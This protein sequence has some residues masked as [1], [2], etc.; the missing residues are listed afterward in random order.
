MLFPVMVVRAVRF[1]LLRGSSV[2]SVVQFWHAP[3]L[4]VNDN[5]TAQTIFLPARNV[6]GC[7]ET[8]SE[9]RGCTLKQCHYADWKWS[10]R[11][12]WEKRS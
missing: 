4:V 1:P 10:A 7:F 8:T 6:D 3:V 5:R 2:V 9:V 12:E 11:S